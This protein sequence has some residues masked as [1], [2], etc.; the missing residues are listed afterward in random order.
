MKLC[1]KKIIFISSIS[2]FGAFFFP[3]SAM[4]QS[5]VVSSNPS[6]PQQGKEFSLSVSHQTQKISDLL[7]Q[8]KQND[9][10]ILEGIGKN[11]LKI[12]QI[13]KSTIN[14]TIINPKT[15][16]KIFSQNIPINP[17][18]IDF[19]WE[20]IGGY[21]PPFYKGKTLPVLQ[22]HI[23]L[24][25]M[26]DREDRDSLYYTWQKDFQNQSSSSGKGKV[27]FAS[28][29]TVL[30]KKNTFS[31]L[32]EDEQ[33]NLS[34]AETITITYGNPEVLFY[35]YDPV[36]GINWNKAIKNDHSV[37]EKGKIILTAIPYF[38][39][40]RDLKN[41][42]LTMQWAINGMKQAFQQ[43]KNLI[44]LAKEPG[45][46]GSSRISIFIDNKN[47]LFQDGEVGIS[48]EF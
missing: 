21:T 48:L 10:L 4:M 47:Y 8:W 33:S 2:I 13:Q 14:L 19:L 30:D 27:S 9:A 3:H 35:E 25:S 7:F 5:F 31:V 34:S 6:I 42:K 22:S 32:V 1:I 39:T 36:L 26:V 16:A 23:N 37:G 12:P 41:P 43:Q 18:S 11:S 17:T 24:V 20:V 45:Q 15:N 46:E 28:I 40:T 29:G 38:L 44:Q